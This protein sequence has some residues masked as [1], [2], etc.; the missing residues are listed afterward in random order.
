MEDAAYSWQQKALPS[1]PPQW[2]VHNTY[3]AW[4][5]LKGVITE[6]VSLL[7]SS[8]YSSFYKSC[9]W[10]LWP[11]Q[12]SKWSGWPTITF[13][14][15]WKRSNYG[16]KSDPPYWALNQPQL[17]LPLQTSFHQKAKVSAQHVSIKKEALNKTCL[18][19]I[20]PCM[21]SKKSTFTSQ[22]LQAH[23]NFSVSLTSR[24]KILDF[25]NN[26]VPHQAVW[27]DVKTLSYL[28]TN[29]YINIRDS[30]LWLLQYEW[31]RCIGGEVA[32]APVVQEPRTGLV[33]FEG[34]AIGAGDVCLQA[35]T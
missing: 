25:T 18:S 27:P 9:T 7:H 30:Q 8:L 16:M 26:L 28:C 13:S 35:G 1:Q 11:S 3:S 14:M 2:S 29:L 33:S 34:A 6:W 20:Q 22:D 4:D 5:H 19:C 23:V 10:C 31:N 32:Q 15:L 21:Q 24:K 12:C 17:P